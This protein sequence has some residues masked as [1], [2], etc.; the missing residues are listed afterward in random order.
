VSNKKGKESVKKKESESRRS[1]GQN[2]FE[3]E[4]VSDSLRRKTLNESR[5]EFWSFALGT[6]QGL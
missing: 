4:G 1:D 3:G 2:R 5:E 6:Q